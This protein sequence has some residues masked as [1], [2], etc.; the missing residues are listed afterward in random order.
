MNRNITQNCSV[1][2]NRKLDADYR[3]YRWQIIVTTFMVYTVMYISRKSFSAVA[4]MLMSDLG[5]TAVSVWLCFFGLLYSVWCS[6]IL[7]WS[8]CGPH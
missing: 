1:K 5:M 6:K 2:I 4:P 7:I 8:C 3:R